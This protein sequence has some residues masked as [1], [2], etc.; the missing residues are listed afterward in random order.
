MIY[1]VDITA[2]AERHIYAEFDRIRELAPMSAEKWFNGIVASILSLST[3]PHRCP[4][5]EEAREL[6]REMRQL[7]YGKRSG[8]FRII[9]DIRV[10]A[11]GENQVRILCVRRGSRD[12]LQPEDL[13]ELEN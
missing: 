9:F 11:A 4:V 2:P 10:T 1:R 7:L 3:L 5:I 12:R 6:G 8:V 13:K